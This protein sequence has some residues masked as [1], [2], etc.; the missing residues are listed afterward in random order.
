MTT[1][2]FFKTDFKVYKSGSKTKDKTNGNDDHFNGGGGAGIKGVR[3]RSQD[4]RL[5]AIYKAKQ[6]RSH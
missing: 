4:G 5:S 2:E 1:T 6:N 3:N